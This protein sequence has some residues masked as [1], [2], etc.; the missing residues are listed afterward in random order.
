MTKAEQ[1]ELDALMYAG[2]PGLP[3]PLCN[4]TPVWVRAIAKVMM[5]N[6]ATGYAIIRNEFTGSPKIEK[7]FGDGAVA[8]YLSIHPYLFLDMRFVPDISNE[9][10]AFAFVRRAYG[11]S[12]KE[13][14]GLPKEKVADLIFAFCAKR[15]L[16]GEPPTP[17]QEKEEPK[18]E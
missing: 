18:E 11:V 16:S 13:V 14:K 9:K 6:L 4:E 1:R 2:V 5:N 10:E 15:Q 12:A 7:L 8:R 17:V 3:E